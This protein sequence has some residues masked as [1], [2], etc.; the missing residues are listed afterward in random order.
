MEGVNVVWGIGCWRGAWAAM[1]RE[2]IGSA[3]MASCTPL[4]LTDEAVA[5]EGK[6]EF[7][8]QWAPMGYTMFLRCNSLALAGAFPGGKYS[9]S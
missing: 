8:I 2:V 4:N 5:V 9:G 1:K 3:C 7:S 6:L